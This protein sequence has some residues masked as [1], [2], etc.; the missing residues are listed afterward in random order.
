MRHSVAVPTTSLQQLGLGLMAMG[1][2]ELQ[3]RVPRHVQ[4]D[5]VDVQHEITEAITVQIP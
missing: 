3:R 1:P 5:A 4:E 2:E